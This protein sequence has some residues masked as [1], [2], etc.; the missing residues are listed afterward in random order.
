MA[1]PGNAQFPNLM[2]PLQLKHAT[3]RNRIIMGSMHTRL[4]MEENGLHKMAVFLEERAKGEAG[5]IITGGY[6]PNTAGLIEPGGPILTERAQVPELRHLTEVVH[7]HGSK[8]CLQILHAGR[9]AKQVECYGPTNVRSRINKFPPQ[10]MTPE[11]IEETIEDYVRCAMLAKEAGFDGAEI[12]GSEGYLINEFTIRYTNDRTDEWGGSE[13]N[14]HRLPVELVKR[15]R[16]ATGPEFIIIYR[17]SALDLVENGATADEIDRLAQR[18][19]EAG[20]DI[21]NTG[22]GWHEARVP[23]IAYP[24]PRAAWRF[25]PARLRRAVKIP[26]VASNRINTPELAEDVLASGDADLISMAR[27]MLADPHFARKVREGNASKINICIACNQACLD[28]IFSDR[29][30]SCLVNPRACRETEFD[31]APAAKSRKVAVIG[32][33]AGGLAAAAEASRRGHSVTLFEAS[34]RV[35]GQINLARMVPGKVEFDEM[36]R[37]FEGLIADGGVRLALNSKPSASELRDSFDAIVVAS[38]VQPRMPDIPGIDH[39][40]VITYTDLLSGKRHA[41]N[42]VAIIGAGGIGFDV[43]EYLCHSHPGEA[44]KARALSDAGFQQEWNIDATLQQ[45]GGLT[46]DPLA[47]RTPTR[48][49]TILQRRP[50]RP[51]ATLGVSTGWILRSSLAKRSVK[52]ITGVAYQRID[53]AGLHVLI[54]NMPQLIEADTIVVCA[55]QDS[56]RSLFDELQGSGIETHIIGGAKEAAELDAMRAVDEG[57]RVAQRL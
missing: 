51:G 8:I 49:I 48:Q 35:G 15:V 16:A 20:A 24:V 33:G 50:S 40:N 42:R 28:R 57:T 53:D 12:M 54:D 4:D 34:D 43:A 11:K 37:Y 32:A 1:D 3:L 13:E 41:G 55:G 47:P 38:G 21:L 26:V 10:A 7:R 30:A 45:P 29:S 52:I 17:I 39:P 27:P 2:A 18:V 22:I 5:L 46:G 6:A 56:N 44:P 36:L 31:E 14:R 19:E 23:T 25:A 9:Y